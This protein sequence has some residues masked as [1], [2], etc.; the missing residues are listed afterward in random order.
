MTVLGGAVVGGI[1]GAF[2]HKGLRLSKDDLA[3]IGGEL[4]GG[5]AVGSGRTPLNTWPLMS[6]ALPSAAA[7]WSSWNT[8]RN[9]FRRLL[10]ATGRRT[11]VSPNCVHSLPKR[12]FTAS[13]SM[14][15][16]K[17][18]SRCAT[19]AF[20]HRAVEYAWL[21][22]ANSSSRSIQSILGI[23][24]PHL[25][26][27]NQPQSQ[28]C[29]ARVAVRR[30]C[31]SVSFNPLGAVHHESPRLAASTF[32]PDAGFLAC[33]PVFARLLPG[34]IHLHHFLAEFPACSVRLFGCTINTYPPI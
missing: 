19:P 26:Q 31:S 33:T 2:F 12:S 22:C 16:P 9:L 1:L 32:P 3:R 27:P 7:V 34:N 17:A 30:C 6:S 23:R 4:D 24:K 13:C 28:C 10:F 29:A 8:T 15:C 18:S 25:N 20:L 21:L 11:R 14:C 5:K